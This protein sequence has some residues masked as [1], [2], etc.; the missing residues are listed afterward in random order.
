MYL[1]THHDVAGGPLTCSVQELK[2]YTW[3]YQTSFRRQCVYRGITGWG[4]REHYL[5]PTSI[6]MRRTDYHVINSTHP[7]ALSN[8]VQ[9]LY[10]GGAHNLRCAA[11]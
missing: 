2:A 6:H 10:C 3:K 5:G 9:T 7:A 8:N 4:A 1:Y 11:V